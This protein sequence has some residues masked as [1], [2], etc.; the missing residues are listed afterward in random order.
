MIHVGMDLHRN[1]SMVVAICDKTGEQFPRRRIDN[2]KS[3]DLWQYLAQ[4]DSEPIR[5]VL[6]ATGNSRWMYRLL[7]SMDNVEP[8]VVVPQKIRI[9]AETV[10]KSDR[11]DAETLAFLSTL[12][13]LPR[14]WVPD[15]AVEELRELTRHRA[16]L[17]RR[18]TQTKNSISGILTRCGLR[19]PYDDMYGVRGLAWLREVELPG[20]MR[21]QVDIWL[22]TLEH[23]ESQIQ[24][25][26]GILYGRLSKSDRWKDDV[27]LLMTMPGVGK[28][29][30]LTILAE[31][32]DYHRFRRRSQVASF[33]GL[34]PKSKR[35]NETVRYGRITRRG[36]AALRTILIEVSLHAVRQSVRYRPLYEKFRSQKRC[37]AGKAAVA[38]QMIEDAWTML[39]KR[40]A[41]HEPLVADYTRQPARVG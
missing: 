33:A 38:R 36:P 40:Q 39:R 20:Y 9:I 11:V 1:N 35:S 7:R 16:A 29:T 32:G 2:A 5:V 18:R 34:T 25:V 22:Q 14:S 24:K 4:F 12:N 26:E 41:F 15:A 28:L 17:V 27:E 3:E 23:I 19:R 30:A 6:E 21:Y 13:A 10:S 31:L 8:V 37:N